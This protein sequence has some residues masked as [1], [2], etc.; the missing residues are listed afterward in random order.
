VIRRR[1][2]WMTSVVIT[3]SS[4]FISP[5][6]ADP[7]AARKHYERGLEELEAGNVSK[8]RESFE[9]A[10]R[11][12]PHYLVLYNLGRASLDLGDLDAARDYLERYLEQGGNRIT[13]EERKRIDSLLQ[14]TRA[15]SSKESSDPVV[16]PAPL[17][18][19]SSVTLP[20]AVPP[21]E[22]P[23]FGAAAPVAPPIVSARRAEEDPGIERRLSR[24]R[25]T[26]AAVMLG[27]TGA[28][29]AVAGVSILVWN[30]D[31]YAE[32]DAA[33]SALGPAPSEMVR[34]QEDL[35]RALAFA[36][37][38]ERNEA[39]R[40]SIQDF[41]AVGWSMAGVGAALLATGV[42][43]YATRPSGPKVTVGIG[44]AKIAVAF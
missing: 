25:R 4:F 37:G 36:R 3:A 29:V 10:Y 8:A 40:R 23:S 32:Y 34:S 1:W 26:T 17:P 35:D 9:E 6:A 30:Q 41:D 16:T 15:K 22:P 31:R 2:A 5:A 11:Q 7:A 38:T 27:A 28:A 12:S 39:F 33:K 43:L 20:P 44:N 42:V 18:A 13:A 24:E 14:A 19:S 21:P